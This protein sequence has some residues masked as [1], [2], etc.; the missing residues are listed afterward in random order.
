MGTQKIFTTVITKR[1]ERKRAQLVQIESEISQ[2]N[3]ELRK[4]CE[5]Q[6]LTASIQELESIIDIGET[7]NDLE[8]E[9]T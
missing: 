1:L 2:N 5:A 3:P 7:I 6:R 4:K 9:S 8:L